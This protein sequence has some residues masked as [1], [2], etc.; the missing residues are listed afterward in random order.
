[1]EKHGRNV[2]RVSP[3]KFQTVLKY[4][5]GGFLSHGGSPSYHPF[6]DG[7]SE[8]PMKS[9]PA[10]HGVPMGTR[11]SWYPPDYHYDLRHENHH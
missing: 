9:S 5:L 11:A 3:V 4:S 2:D 6:I 10:I 8:F 7:I 1:M